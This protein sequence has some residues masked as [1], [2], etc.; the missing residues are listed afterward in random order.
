MLAKLYIEKDGDGVAAFAAME[1]GGTQTGS[2]Q[3]G[4]YQHFHIFV[5]WYDP[6]LYIIIIFM[7]YYI[8]SHYHY[9]VNMFKSIIVGI[10]F[11]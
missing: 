5:F 11:M 4:S 6:E 3:T 9:V 10:I 1:L 2:Y 7:I 8:Q